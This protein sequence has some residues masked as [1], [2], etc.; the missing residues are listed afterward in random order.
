MEKVSNKK[1]S[2]ESPKNPSGSPKNTIERARKS[3]LS[4]AINEIG[5]VIIAADQ[6]QTTSYHCDSKKLTQ[7]LIVQEASDVFKKLGAKG[8]KRV[9]ELSTLE[10]MLILLYIANLFHYFYVLTYL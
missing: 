4:S 6:L 5:E 10:G 2:T 8:I 1:K 7:L 3:N 9:R